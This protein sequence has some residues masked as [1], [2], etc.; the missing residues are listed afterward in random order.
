[1]GGGISRQRRDVIDELVE[2]VTEQPINRF[3]LLPNEI[4]DLIAREAGTD[5]SEDRDWV[6]DQLRAMGIPLNQHNHN[7]LWQPRID[8][9]IRMVARMLNGPPQPP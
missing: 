9:R 1:M 4:N 8:N 3:E 7:A 5:I 6:A 2:A